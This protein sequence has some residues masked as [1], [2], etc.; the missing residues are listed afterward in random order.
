MD[1][2]KVIKLDEIGYKILPCCMNCKFGNFYHL[3]F[4]ECTK[5]TY[6]HLKHDNPGGSRPLSIHASGTCDDFDAA[7]W[8][9]DGWLKYEEWDE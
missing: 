3:G 7:Q 4:G 2:N 1:A 9:H 5:Q 6:V 8:L